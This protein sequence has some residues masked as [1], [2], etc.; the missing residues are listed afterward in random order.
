MSR[1]RYGCNMNFCK[2]DLINPFCVNFGLLF[3]DQNHRQ[4]RGLAGALSKPSLA[5]NNNS[6]SRKSLYRKLGQHDKRKS[7]VGSKP[8]LIK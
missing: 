6:K 5:I 1:T 4:N 8:N 2:N 3:S 7:K